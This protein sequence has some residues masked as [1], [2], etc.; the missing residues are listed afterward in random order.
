MDV[1]YSIFIYSELALHR[2]EH[3]EQPAMPRAKAHWL[4]NAG[5]VAAYRGRSSKTARN[6]RV[7]AEASGG[8]MVVE[9]IGRQ[10]V[11]VRLTVKQENLVP[12][13]P[14]LFD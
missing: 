3:W 7:I 10:G 14:G 1:Q 2:P 5:T 13:Q 9:A 12:M 6:V 11:P 4:P 8:R